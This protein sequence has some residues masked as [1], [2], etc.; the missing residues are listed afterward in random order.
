MAIAMSTFI[1]RLILR[2]W[3]TNNLEQ[4]KVSYFTEDIAIIE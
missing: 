2:F 4:K 3:G 1:V